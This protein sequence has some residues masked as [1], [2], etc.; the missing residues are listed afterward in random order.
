MQPDEID[1][2]MQPTTSRAI[3][4]WPAWRV[5]HLRAMQRG[6]AAWI[7]GG[8]ECEQPTGPELWIERQALLA[9][10]RRLT[11]EYRAAALRAPRRRRW[12]TRTRT[13]RRP[14]LWNHKSSV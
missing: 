9:D 2:L 10:A 1:E 4:G 11:A 6:R 5:E 12:S 13:S 7:A 14:R 8:G 3:A